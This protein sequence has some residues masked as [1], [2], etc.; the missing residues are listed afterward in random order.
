[1]R[2]HLAKPRSRAR[3][4]PAL[5]AVIVAG[6][7]GGLFPALATGPPE[8][9]VNLTPPS[10]EMGAFYNGADVRIEGRVER[11]ASPIVAVRGADSK[12]AFNKKGRS[13][14]IWV[15]AGKVEISGVPSLFLCFSA[16]PVRALLGPESIDK[17][18]LDEAALKRHLLI[19]PAKMDQEVIRDHYLKMKSAEGTLRIFPDGV[20]MGVP[21][22]GGTPFTVRFQWPKTAPPGTYEVSVYE[23]RDG[24][25]TRQS[26][27]PLRVVAVGSPAA[28]GRLAREHGTLY[29]MIA[30]LVAAMAGFGM[31]FV[32]ARLLKRRR[33]VRIAIP[34]PAAEPAEPAPAAP[35]GA[36]TRAGRRTDT[37]G[38][39]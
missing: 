20:T 23:C 36:G 2:K 8:Q 32:A 33:R 4:A 25:I 28:L 30:V 12:E 27:V 24:A 11:G 13:G 18:R 22:P 38:K 26:S 1:M 14:P 21:A 3:R 10:I 16:A 9:V 17:H 6:C 7:L 31:D 15:N 35:V 19:E 39:A 29:G 34:T 5:T 37:T